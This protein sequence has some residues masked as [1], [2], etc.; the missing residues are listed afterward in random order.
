[1][2]FNKTIA[3]RQ[4]VRKFTEAQIT[5][6]QLKAILE[7]ANA[8]PAC[9]GQYDHLHLTVVQKPEILA[10]IN[11]AFQKAVGDPNMQVTY[12]APTVI[13]VLADRSRRTYVDDGNMVIANILNAAHAV[14]VDSCYI[15]RAREVFNT[16]EGKELLETWGVNGDYE[17]IGNVIL[18]YGLP[19]GIREAVPRKNDYIVRV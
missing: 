19:E 10:Q 1:M 16:D 9:M 8:A 7:A 3:A 2:E 4:S 6:E 5:D 17:G 15:Y 11:A 18:G 12:G 14:G 13:V